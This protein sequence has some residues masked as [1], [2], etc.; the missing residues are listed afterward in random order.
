MVISE[1]F[2]VVP[3]CVKCGLSVETSLPSEIVNTCGVVHAFGG[4]ATVEATSTTARI[5]RKNIG[6]GSMNAKSRCHPRRT[7]LRNLLLFGEQYSNM[8]PECERYVK[9]TNSA[10]RAM[11]GT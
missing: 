1:R 7:G 2:A 11:Y 9:V 3:A 10:S 5:V 8:M 6:I 4:G